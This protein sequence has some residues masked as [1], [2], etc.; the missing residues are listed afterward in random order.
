MPYA[1]TY[2]DYLT[3]LHGNIKLLQNSA[4]ENILEAQ[5]ESKNNYDSNAKNMSLKAGDL[6]LRQ[7][8]YADKLGKFEPRYTGPFEV[9]SSTDKTANV[10]QGKK[11]RTINKNLLHLALLK[12]TPNEFQSVMIRI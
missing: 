10:R 1:K 5:R 6:V 11:V 7:L 8:P 4:R 2:G 12:T 3:E 9:V